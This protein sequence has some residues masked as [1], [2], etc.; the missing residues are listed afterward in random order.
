M[1]LATET[2]IPGVRVVSVDLHWD[3]RGFFGE[4]FNAAAFQSAG[5][6][7]AVRQCNLS[8]TRRK[9]GIRGMHW[10]EEPAGQAKL[11]VCLRGSA[12]DVAVD[13]RTDSPAYGQSIG[14]K[15]WSTPKERG[16]LRGLYLPKDCAHGWQALEEGSQVLYFVDAPWSPAHERGLRPEDPALSIAWPL[17]PAIVSPR[18]ASWPAFVPR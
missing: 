2:S 18:D 10:Q 5:I 16:G 15:L 13:V 4:A 11:V 12:W 14:L 8:M 6:P 1:I 9:G 7:F 17:P 3:E